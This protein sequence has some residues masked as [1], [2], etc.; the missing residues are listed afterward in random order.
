MCA[1]S[2]GINLAHIDVSVSSL[3]ECQLRAQALETFTLLHLYCNGVTVSS[4]SQDIN[5]PSIYTIYIGIGCTEED[6]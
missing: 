6:N 4:E 2:M 1:K 3:R 5:A